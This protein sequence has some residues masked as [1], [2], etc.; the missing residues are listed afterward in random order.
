VTLN[1]SLGN[2]KSRM[3]SYC[4]ASISTGNLKCLALPITKIIMIGAKFKRTG[5]A[6]LS[7]PLLWVVCHR[8]LG[9]DTVYRHAKFDDSSFSHSTDI[10]VASKFKV[11]HVTL[12][13]YAHLMVICHSYAGT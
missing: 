11:G 2:N 10:I 4:S 12:T 9:F 13:T 1:T 8:R 3:H 5:H 7:M 6:T